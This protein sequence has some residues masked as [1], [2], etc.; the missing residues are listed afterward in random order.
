MCAAALLLFR[1]T[2][3]LGLFLLLPICIVMTAPLLLATT[4]YLLAYDVVLFGATTDGVTFTPMQERSVIAA[5][6]LLVLAIAV[7]AIY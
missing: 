2:R 4:F 7:R 5:K 6:V 1:R 3:K